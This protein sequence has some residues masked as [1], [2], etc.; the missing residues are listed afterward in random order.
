M[1][2]GV[3]TQIR[4]WSAGWEARARMDAS[5]GQSKMNQEGIAAARVKIL[6]LQNIKGH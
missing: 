2:A 3:V 4:D 5:L 6:L 1:E